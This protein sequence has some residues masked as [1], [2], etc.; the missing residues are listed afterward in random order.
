M[1]SGASV[2][3]FLIFTLAGYLADTLGWEAV[4]YV[5]GGCTVVW[6]IAWFY[7][8]YDTPASHPRIDKEEKEYIETSLGEVDIDRCLLT[9]YV[10]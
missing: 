4:F 7:L 3:T 6:V 1:Q 5:T 8:A 10:C 2:G 9:T